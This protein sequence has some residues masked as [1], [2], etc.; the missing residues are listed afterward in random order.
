MY[1]VGIDVI[2]GKLV[3]VNVFRASGTT[4]FNR[5]NRA[6]LQSDLLDFI[7]NVVLASELIVERKKI[8]H[9]II[10]YADAI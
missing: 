5:L 4:D 6:K 3:D 2:G 1:F 10:D 9:E 8:F 7:G